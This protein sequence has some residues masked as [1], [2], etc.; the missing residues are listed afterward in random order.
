[1]NIPHEVFWQFVNFGIFAVLLFV[2]LRKKVVSY[3]QEREAQFKQ[4]LIKAEHARKEA[5]EQKKLIQQKLEKLEMSAAEDVARAKKEA[6][7]LKQK[8][9]HDA[10][11]IM[12]GMKKDAELSAQSEI[13]RAKQELREELLTQALELSKKLLKEKMNEPDQKRLQ[14]E[15]VDKI[16]VVLQ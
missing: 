16:Q 2:L 8:I 13:N 11:D 14:N 6:E 1:M 3:Y 15:F 4:A 12:A 9:V 10:Q 5:E 7:E